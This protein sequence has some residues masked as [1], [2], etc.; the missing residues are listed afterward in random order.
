MNVLWPS[1]QTA[2]QKAFMMKYIMQHALNGYRQDNFRFLYTKL[3]QI[4]KVSGQ[5]DL[6]EH[7]TVVG[8]NK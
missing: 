3:W 7:N 6:V 1:H 2:V 4:V 8:W 5:G